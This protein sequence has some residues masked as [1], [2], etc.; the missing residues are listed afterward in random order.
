M[1]LDFPAQSIIESWNVP[2]FIIIE[3]PRPLSRWPAGNHIVRLCMSYVVA[4]IVPPLPSLQAKSRNIN[5][6]QPIKCNRK[7][8]NARRRAS[9]A[10]A[11]VERAILNADLP[12]SPMAQEKK[13]LLGQSTHQNAVVCRPRQQKERVRNAGHLPFQ[14]S[15]RALRMDFV[16]VICRHIRGFSS[17]WLCLWNACRRATWHR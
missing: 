3:L 1:Q 14:V 7:P 16:V 9:R 11:T 10:S 17:S 8:E 4:T 12:I 6:P 2:A 5:D 13:R 15:C